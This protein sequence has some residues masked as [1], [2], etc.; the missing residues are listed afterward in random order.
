MPMATYQRL[1]DDLADFSTLETIALWGF[2]EPLLHPEIVDMVRLAHRRGI[3][4][5]I[6]TNGLLLTRELS[7][8]LVAAGLCTLVVSVDGT[9]PD[10]FADARSG[11]DFRKLL[12]NMSELRN[13]KYRHR[14]H[15][16]TPEI[17]IEF[18]VMRRNVSELPELQRLADMLGASFVIVTN[19]LPYDKALSDEILYRVSAGEPFTTH[20]SLIM[21]ETTLPQID[22]YGENLNFVLSLVRNGNITNTPMRL[23]SL[24]WADYCPFINK[25]A[26]AVCR[27]GSVSPCIAL[28][29][30]HTCYV[31]GR[32]KSMRRY[33]VGDLAHESLSAIWNK[34]EY[35]YFRERVVIFDFPPCIHCGGCDD[36]DANERD[37]F[38][39]PFPVCGDCLWARNVILCP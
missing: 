32:E 33:V 9:S 18:V 28:M 5:E 29:H 20:R 12:E 3:K 38:D 24:P 31:M 16:A 37:C 13:A 25:G 21:P 34:S 7:E 4:T 19:V 11:A 17:G 15:P 23:S 8:E 10:S 2:G 35:T 26:L 22:L 30:S 1:I 39:N 6:V 27:D 36:S 14:R